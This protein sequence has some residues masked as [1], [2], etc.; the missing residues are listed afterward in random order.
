[1]QCEVKAEA[2]KAFERTHPRSTSSPSRLTATANMRIWL[3]GKIDVVFDIPKY[4][5]LNPHIKKCGIVRNRH[6]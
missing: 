2:L 3:T 1:M 5:T 6:C 4:Y